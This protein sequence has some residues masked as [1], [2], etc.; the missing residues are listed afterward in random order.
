MESLNIPSKCE[1]CGKRKPSKVVFERGMDRGIN[2]HLYLKF[3][4]EQ[5][6][7]GEINDE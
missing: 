3:I 6:V 4:C 2:A 7:K 1:E 5:C